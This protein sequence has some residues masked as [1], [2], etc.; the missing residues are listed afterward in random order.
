MMTNRYFRISFLLVVGLAIASLIAYSQIKSEKGGN[1]IVATNFGGPF[2][3]T[4]QNGKT[5]TEEIFKNQY[6]L[7]YFGFTYCPAICPT[8]LQKMTAT[9]NALGPVGEKI[10]PVFIT[11]DPER[12]TVQTMKQYIEA[13]HPNFVG[14]TGTIA[15]IDQA[16][17]SYKIY[18][19]KVQDD[20]MS[21]YTMDHSSYIYFLDPDNNLI[22]IF[23]IDDTAEAMV[24]TIRQYITK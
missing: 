16:K 1:H 6:R 9:L 12:D 20:T 14:L 13:F 17:K 3:L 5:V 23:K 15:Q 18:A 11:V 7:I 10:L 8:E 4:N 22:R 24:T 21:D 2:T 19:A